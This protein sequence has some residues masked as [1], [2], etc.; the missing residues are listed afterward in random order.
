MGKWGAGFEPRRVNLDWVHPLTQLPSLGGNLGVP[1]PGVRRDPGS[2]PG[3]AGEEGC[4]ARPARY[5]FA[6][7]CFSGYRDSE[8]QACSARAASAPPPTPPPAARPRLEAQRPA[9]FVTRR[10]LR[11][12]AHPQGRGAQTRG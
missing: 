5:P 11:G 1:S 3:A 7:P 6:G 9:A 2:L 4:P 10:H 12:S 8:R